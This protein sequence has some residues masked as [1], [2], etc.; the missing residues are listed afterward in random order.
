MENNSDLVLTDYQRA[1]LTEMGVSYWQLADASEQSNKQSGLA[2]AKQPDD[3]VSTNSTPLV[4]SQL[5]PQEQALARL[6]ALKEGSN[7]VQ[8]TDEVLLI[9][10]EGNSVQSVF[11]DVL[12][13]L[14]LET[15][16]Q[17]H[18]S[19]SQLERYVDYPLAW[20]QGDAISLSNNQ[21]TTPALDNLSP[22]LKKQLWQQMQKVMQ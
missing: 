12:M 5:F 21:L 18:I 19:I 6:K 20:K 14:E 4:D 9:W 11:N 1:V 3:G 10:P 7:S 16:S 15:K 17:K 13:A 2:Q 8:S 22:Q